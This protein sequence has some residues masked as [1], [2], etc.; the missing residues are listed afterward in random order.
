MV[1]YCYLFF[2]DNLSVSKIVIK[3]EKSNSNTDIQENYITGL[4]IYGLNP[5]KFI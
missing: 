1:Y 3:I 5:N 4:R 2:L